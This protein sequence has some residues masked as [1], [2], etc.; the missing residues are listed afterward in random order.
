MD[1]EQTGQVEVPEWVCNDDTYE[2][3]LDQVRLQLPPV[4]S[5]YKRTVDYVWPPGT[6]TLY[7]QTRDEPRGGDYDEP[8]IVPSREGED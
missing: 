7:W 3:F 8:A 6:Q 4:K 2:L 1:V 5:G